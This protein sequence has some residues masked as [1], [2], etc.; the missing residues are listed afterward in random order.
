[1]PFGL[2]SAPFAFRRASYSA[3]GRLSRPLG[4][5][6]RLAAHSAFTTARGELTGALFG[7]ELRLIKQLDLYRD[8]VEKE[9]VRKRLAEISA[10]RSHYWHSRVA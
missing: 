9:F 5:G 10:E 3:G 4:F 2:A 1:M 6:E 8:D 7:G